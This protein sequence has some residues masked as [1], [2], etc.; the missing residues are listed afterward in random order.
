[1]AL[2]YLSSHRSYPCWGF[3]VGY[4]Y[5]YFFSRLEWC[6]PVEKAEAFC[7]SSHGQEG[8][9]GARATASLHTWLE[10]GQ[11]ANAFLG[12]GH[13]LLETDEC[14]RLG[15]GIPARDICGGCSA[16]RANSKLETESSAPWNA[17]RGRFNRGLMT[18]KPSLI[19]SIKTGDFI[20]HTSNAHALPMGS[21]PAPE[22]ITVRVGSFFQQQTVCYSSFKSVQFRAAPGTAS[23]Q[24][25]LIR[26]GRRNAPK[27]CSNRFNVDSLRFPFSQSFSLVLF[28]CYFLSWKN[29]IQFNPGSFKW[30]AETLRFLQ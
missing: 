16:R 11:A 20:K 26:M 2:S 19:A 29:I 3:L 7:L 13:D 10:P 30:K 1:M 6:E 9:S 24:G 15:E 27:N 18:L 8:W 23:N 28:H 4:F 5:F 12:L 14:C 25:Y 17:K 22:V 21:I